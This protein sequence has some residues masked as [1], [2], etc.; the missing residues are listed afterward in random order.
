MA[1]YLILASVI[2]RALVMFGGQ[3]RLMVLALLIVYGVLLVAYQ[4]RAAWFAADRRRAVL[5]LGVQSLLVISLILLP[6]HFDYLPL[7]FIPLSLYAVELLGRRFGFMWIAAFVLVMFW[8]YVIAVEVLDQPSAVD[9]PTGLAMTLLYGGF[10]YLV[11][12]IA[13]VRRQAEI[14]RRHN[15]QML[16]DLQAAHRQLQD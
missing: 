9:G 12:Q 13:H 6:P 15:Q 10:G 8:Q 5:Y 2:I 3:R 14:T 7:L 1:V 11:G 16:I 4:Q